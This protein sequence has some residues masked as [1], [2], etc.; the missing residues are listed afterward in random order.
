MK[1]TERTGEADEIS[2]AR[3][4]EIQASF[5]RQGFME[6]IG[7]RLVVLG[8]GRCVIEMPFSDEVAQQQGLFH[9]GAI[10][11]LADSAGGYAAMTLLPEGIDVV[12]LEYK[13]NFLRPAAGDAVIATGEVLRA[14]RSV[15][16]TRVDIHVRRAGQFVLCAAMQQSVVPAQPTEQS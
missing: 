8:A 11:A 13:L 14:G 16:V 7:A 3:R 6:K 10:G 12:T 9:G 1:E 15:V 4:G 2:D 5:S